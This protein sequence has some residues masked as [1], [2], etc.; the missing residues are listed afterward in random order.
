[1]AI[2]A[3][4]LPM[5]RL[6]LF[7]LDNTLVQRDRAFAA[8][9]QEFTAEHDLD[10]KW[11]TWLIFADA[12]H[13][14]PMDTFFDIVRDEFALTTPA[15]ELWRQYR[16]R[17]PQLVSCS[18]EDLA[19][20]AKLRRQDWKIGIVTNGMTDNQLGKIRN[21]G[22]DRHVD[23]WCISHDVGIRKP[24]PRIFQLAAHRCGLTLDGGGWM[25][26]DSL[27]LDI[28][29]GACAGLRTVWI[30]E[31]RLA[32]QHATYGPDFFLPPAPD[33]TVM[34]VAEAVD[35]LLTAE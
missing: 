1:M 14:G 5:Q 9:A 23:A 3:S 15:D 8:W 31:P 35:V 16:H 6:A 25:I 17:M 18:A 34:S 26:G 21:T 33:A 10:P 2:A 32:R 20:L 12:H 11:A 29:G 7:D 27:I 19:G 22:L 4:C 24:D 30:P 28:A 13:D